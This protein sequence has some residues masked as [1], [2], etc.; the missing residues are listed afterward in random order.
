MS[1]V[2]IGTTH[3]H[4]PAKRP[5]ARSPLRTT[6][7]NSNNSQGSLTM[8]LPKGKER[9]IIEISSDSEDE[10]LVNKPPRRRKKEQKLVRGV[11]TR[12]SPTTIK[13]GLGDKDVGEILPVL[14]RKFQEVSISCPHL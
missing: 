8:E 10:G 4:P 12:E 5:R 14:K 11:R 1:T 7:S 3:F 6:H 2:T 9:E 13:P